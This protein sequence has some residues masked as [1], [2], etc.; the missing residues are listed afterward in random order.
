MLCKERRTSFKKQ[1]YT[2][3][4]PPDKGTPPSAWISG[5]SNE[6][7]VVIDLTGNGNKH[8]APKARS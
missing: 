4:V 6:P 5:E 7:A 3:V 1:H 2:P 8:S